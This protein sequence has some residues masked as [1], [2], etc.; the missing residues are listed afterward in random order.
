MAKKNFGNVIDSILM[1]NEE[2]QQPQAAAAETVTTAA[3]RGKGRPKME[4][5]ERRTFIVRTDLFRKLSF[6]AGKEDI[7]QKDILEVSLEN[8]IKAYEAKNG[9]IDSLSLGTGKKS[10]RD[11]I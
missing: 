5:Y 11:I 8:F 6:I 3:P 9:E 4:G 1:G 10:A 7:L 2:Q